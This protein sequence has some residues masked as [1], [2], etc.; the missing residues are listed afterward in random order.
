MPPKLAQI[1]E[2]LEERYG[3]EKLAGPRNPYEMT[4]PRGKSWIPAC[5]RRLKRDKGLT[6]CSRSMGRRFASAPSRNAR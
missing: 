6:C 1:L 3:T 5:Q 4:A 2:T